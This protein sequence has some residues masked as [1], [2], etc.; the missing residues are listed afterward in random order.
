MD[1][2]ITRVGLIGLGIMGQPMSANLL[3]GGFDVTVYSRTQ[4]KVDA[5]RQLGARPAASP[6][7]VAG[8]CEMVIVIVTDSADVEEVARG[9]QGVFAGTRPGLIVADMSTISPAV[10]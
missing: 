4:S 5:L 3:K 7:E 9:S 2:A 1:A 8:S 10:T 6:A